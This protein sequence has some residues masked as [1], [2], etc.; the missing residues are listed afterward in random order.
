MGVLA[1]YFVSTVVF[2]GMRDESLCPR[3]MQEGVPGWAT[4]VYFISTTISTVG[5]G[6]VNVTQ[7]GSEP[8]RVFIVTL[9]M[10]LAMVIAVTIFSQ[11]AT[12]TVE[13]T[14]GYTSPYIAS[15]FKRFKNIADTKPLWYQLRTVKLIR[16]FELSLY[17]VLLNLCGTFVARIIFA[18]GSED[19]DWNWM[20]TFYWSVQTTTTIGYG[21][22]NMPYSLR[23]F[24]IFY[25]IIG[26]T[27]AANLL[28]NLA[29]LKNEIQNIRRFY[30][31]KNRE[32]SMRLIEDMN[33][34]DDG[35]LDAYEFLIG[36]LIT[37]EKIQKDD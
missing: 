2:C 33:G 20:T 28:G 17:F 15:L 26:T 13:L 27:F 14:R 12:S 37:L 23:W 25:T 18:A 22:L 3:G 31:W 34:D 19:V 10:I 16:L 35:H 21:D 30:V 24:N 29:D 5:Y 9:F 4:T 32:V 6:D 1:F 8:W 11:L 36:S 7:S